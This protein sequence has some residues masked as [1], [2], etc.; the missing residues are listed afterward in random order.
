M[1][2]LYLCVVISAYIANVREKTAVAIS[3]SVFPTALIESVCICKFVGT[4][5]GVDA[6]SVMRK[7]MVGSEFHTSPL[8]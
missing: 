4:S 7:M 6:V 3:N 2:C 8:L 1:L 5:F